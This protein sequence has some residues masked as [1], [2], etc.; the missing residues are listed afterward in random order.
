MTRR[1]LAKKRKRILSAGSDDSSDS[2][3]MV[4]ESGIQ[5]KPSPPRKLRKVSAV[6]AAPT[7][8]S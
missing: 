2:G 6:A 5:K 4:E 1:A 7:A 8:P 3:K